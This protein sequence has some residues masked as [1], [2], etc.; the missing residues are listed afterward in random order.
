VGLT[1]WVV[2]IIG[3]GDTLGLMNKSY[4]V[5]S[6]CWVAIRIVLKVIVLVIEYRVWCRLVAVG[7]DLTDVGYEGNG[8]GGDVDGGFG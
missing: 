2:G 1:E 4:Y 6:R 3:R 8:V 7:Y 5:F